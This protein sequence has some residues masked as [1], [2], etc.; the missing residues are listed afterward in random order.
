MNNYNYKILPQAVIDLDNHA[1]FIAQ[2]NLD[3]GL[4]L[5][6]MAAITYEMICDMPNIGAI[7]ETSKPNLLGM[8]LFAIKEYSRYLVYYK[9]ING[10]INIVRVLHVRTDR[11]KWF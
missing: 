1:A 11:D 9:S 4:R 8:R 3:A 7:H 10:F 2:D 6:D 5:Y